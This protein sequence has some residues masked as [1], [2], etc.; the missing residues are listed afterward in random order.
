MRM[1]V[2]GAGSLGTII[3]AL[4]TKGGLEIDLI[5]VNTAHVNALKE[6]G[7]KITGKMELEVPVK[8]LTPDE[9]AGEYDLFFYLVKATHNEE[10]LPKVAQHLK[11]DG[12]VVTMQ[13]GIPE[14]SVAAVVGRER[15]LGCAVGWG[16][17]LVAPGVSMLASDLERM[18]YD[19]GELDGQITDR[20]KKII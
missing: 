5:D 13:N 12:V 16:A 7:A 3:G 19:I 14:E 1:A 4:I 6:R 9:M 15:T 18:T 2:M 20:L 11:S 10:A 17:A 8:A